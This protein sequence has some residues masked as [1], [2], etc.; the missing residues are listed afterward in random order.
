VDPFLYS[1]PARTPEG[2][3]GGG[4]KWL[5]REQDGEVA[6]RRRKGKRERETSYAHY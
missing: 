6:S 1:L 2:R 3:E 5:W 4:S